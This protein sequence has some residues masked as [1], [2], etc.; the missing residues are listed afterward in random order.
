MTKALKLY[1]RLKVKG[2]A[3]CKAKYSLSY[4]RF[5]VKPDANATLAK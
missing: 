4:T 2:K 5:A 3:Y 1:L